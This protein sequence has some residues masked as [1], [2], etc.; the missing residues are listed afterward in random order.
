[1]LITEAIKKV[2]EREDLTSEEAEA[3]LDQIMTGQCTDAQIASLLTA[4]RMKGET[5]DELTGFARVMRRKAAP[6]RPQTLVSALGGTEREARARRGQG[7]RFA[8]LGLA[9]GVFR[10]DRRH[11]VQ[12]HEAADGDEYH[13][14]FPPQRV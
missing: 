14:A 10:I 12:R 6:V 5:V 3:V 13:Q 9:R 2:V 4:L 8:K 11:F 1:M 7:G